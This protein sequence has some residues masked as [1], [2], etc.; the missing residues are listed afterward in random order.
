[1]NVYNKTVYNEKLVRKYNQYYLIQFLVTKFVFM[2]FLIALLAG[3]L[4]YIHMTQYLIW[5]GVFLV[6][7]LLILLLINRLSIR[8]AINSSEEI[9]RGL[10]I[11]FVFRDDLMIPSIREEVAYSQIRS[12]KVWKDLWIIKT[13]GQAIHLVD[14]Q[15][16]ESVEQEKR[17]YD[18]IKSKMFNK[19]KKSK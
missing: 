18:T 9:R 13:Q 4:I 11:E 10:I 17:C 2:A 12:F 14:V 8:K 1:M 5:I 7:Y 6:F 19:T 15:G 16:F 3:Y